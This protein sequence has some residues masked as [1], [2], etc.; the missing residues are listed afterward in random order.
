MLQSLVMAI[1]MW[2]LPLTLANPEDPESALNSIPKPVLQRARGMASIICN[3]R[4]S[5]LTT[6]LLGLAVFQVIVCQ[7]IIFLVQALYLL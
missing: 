1:E 7:F 3:R 2:V 6:D 4:E 5:R